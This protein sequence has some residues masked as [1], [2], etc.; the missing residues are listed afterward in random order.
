LTGAQ[1]ARERFDGLRLIAGGLERTLELELHESFGF[2]RGK[3]I[4]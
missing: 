3:H 2:L 1:P 4:A